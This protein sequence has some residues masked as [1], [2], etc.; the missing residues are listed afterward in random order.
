MAKRMLFIGAGA[1]GSYLGSF[2]ARAGHDVVLVD[3]WPEQV[4]MI[5]SR[6]IAVTGPHDPFEAK[7]PALHVHELQRLGADFDIAFIA[8]KAYDTAWATHL[9][10]PYLSAEGFVVSLQNCLNEETIAGIVG[11]GR[12][13]GVIA[14]LISVDLYEA[15]RI[16]RTVHKGGDKYTIF[17]V[18]E[19]HGVSLGMDDDGNILDLDTPYPG[20]NMFSLASGG[21]IYVRGEVE[22]WQCGKEVGVFAA[23]DEDMADLTPVLKEYCEDLGM[24]LD[25]VL[26]VPFTKLVPVSHRPY[27][28]L[29]TY[30]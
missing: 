3:P 20:S 16:R 5:R 14:S 23:N 2:L 4:E 24:D 26:S 25:E 6:G 11:W 17:R 19:P 12:V 29:Y 13:V 1:I 27:G 30:L 8:M 21:A 7:P 10:R 9:I 22:P 18:G 28:K 15:G